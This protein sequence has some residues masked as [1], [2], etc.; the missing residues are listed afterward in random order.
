MF[1]PLLLT[2][3]LALPTLVSAE[4]PRVITDIG[5]VESLTAMVMGDLGAPDRLLQ[6]GDSPHHMALRPS[7]ARALSN[8][9][10]V[11]WI[12][13]D[14]TPQLAGQ[15]ETLATS[16]LSLPLADLTTTHLLPARDTGLFPH[17]HEEEEE[18]HHDDHDEDHEDHAEDHDE[19]AH[20][21]GLHDPHVW[22]S[23]ENAT[24]WLADIAEA[25]AETDPD[26]AETYRTNAR[27]GAETIAAAEA[28]AHTTLA[29]LN[30][31][32]L[33]VAHDAYQ[34]FEHD[35]GLTVLGAISDA[36]ANTP[37][38]ARLAALRDGLATDK[39]ACL[40]IEP[41]TDPRLLQTIEGSGLP[42]ATL[43]PLGSDLPQGATLYPALIRTFAQRIATCVGD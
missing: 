35:F 21:H 27:T 32:P 28:E 19:D 8:A 20:G 17:D 34:Y 2:A 39:P 14:L 22:L 30:G 5:P 10:L 6:P 31:R 26:N 42:T 16:A 1:R 11:I 29:P 18:D 12:G 13:P 9:D 4:V 15:I 36:E 25:L 3:G 7:Q 38:P 23:P 41:G 37:G 33:A 40:L 43:D 24:H